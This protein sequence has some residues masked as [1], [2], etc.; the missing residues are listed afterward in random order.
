[1]KSRW[2]SRQIRALGFLCGLTALLLTG[3][4]T[5]QT[6]QPG[7]VGVTRTQSIMG[8]HTQGT[9]EMNQESALAYTT[10]IK[11]AQKKN[12]LNPDKAQTERVRRIADRLIPQVVIFRPDARSWAWEVNVIESKEINAWCMPGGKIAVFTGLIEQLKLTDDELAAVIG[13]EISHALREHALERKPRVLAAQVGSIGLLLGG[14]FMGIDIPPDLANS[15]SMA[16]L[17]LPNSREQE[18]EADRMGLELAARAG[19]DPRA[20]V[21]L[22]QKMGQAGGSAPPKILSSH[23]PSEERQADLRATSQ[24][25]M[26][27]YEEAR[28]NG[29]PR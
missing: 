25:V 19:F 4:Q 27:L 24:V 7:A 17:A 2:Q 29:T 23:P 13:H 6:T 5:I 10:T 20:A 26:P 11:D 3:C 16:A 9:R 14:A 28:K 21:T 15:A 22:W 8:D 1:M 18:T 12:Q